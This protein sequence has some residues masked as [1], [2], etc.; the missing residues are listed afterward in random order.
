MI[1]FVSFVVQQAV[2]KSAKWPFSVIPVKIGFLP[3]AGEE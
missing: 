1:W 3:T 2:D